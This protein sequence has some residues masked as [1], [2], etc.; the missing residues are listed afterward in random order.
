MDHYV[1]EHAERVVMLDPFDPRTLWIMLKR[2]ERIRQS[3]GGHDKSMRKLKRWNYISTLQTIFHIK[4]MYDEALDSWIQLYKQL[5]DSVVVANIKENVII[6]SY[7]QAME[8]VAQIFE[9]RYNSGLTGYTRPWSI[10]TK[11]ARTGNKEM[12][13]CYLEKAFEE[14]DADIH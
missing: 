12:A 2:H 8:V 3:P 10:A 4:R 11:Y 6:G 13:L 9:A 1:L 14:H 5:D 7:E